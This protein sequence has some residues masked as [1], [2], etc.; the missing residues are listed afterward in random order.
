MCD[1]LS[2]VSFPAW[3]AEGLIEDY[4]HYRRGE[5]SAVYSELRSALVAAGVQGATGK[6]SSSFETF[7]RDYAPM[8]IG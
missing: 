8:F 7:V 4:A 1:S 6:A 3:Q 2:K 5:A